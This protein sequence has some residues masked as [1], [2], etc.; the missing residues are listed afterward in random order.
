MSAPGADGKG[1]ALCKGLMPGPLPGFRG[2]L[3][4]VLKSDFFFLQPGEVLINFLSESR[5]Q[6]R[7][8]KAAAGAVWAAGVLRG[9]EGREQPY[10]LGGHPVRFLYQSPGSRVLYVGTSPTCQP[11]CSMLLGS[12]LPARSS[13]K[14]RAPLPATGGSPSAETS[15]VPQS[16]KISQQKVSFVGLEPTTPHGRRAT[17]SSILPPLF[18]A[19]AGLSPRGVLAQQVPPPM[20]MYPNPF[21]LTQESF[22]QSCFS[23]SLCICSWGFF[24]RG[25]ST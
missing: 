4:G 9:M 14:L 25:L 15:P 24:L 17:Q 23:V 1:P 16:S 6:S 5:S 11:R 10:K 13:K 2:L 20:Q 3:P 8:R 19:T 7:R 18:A 12:K 22:A 21:A